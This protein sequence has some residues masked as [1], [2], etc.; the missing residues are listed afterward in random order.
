MSPRPSPARLSRLSTVAIAAAAIAAFASGSYLFSGRDAAAFQAPATQGQWSPVYTVNAPGAALPVSAIHTNVLPNGKVLLWDLTPFHTFNMT[1]TWLW[2][3]TETVS[4]T[5]ISVQKIVNGRTVIFCSGHAFLPDGRLFVAGGGHGQTERIAQI[6]IFDYRTNSWSAGPDMPAVPSGP[7]PTYPNVWAGRWYPTVTALANGEM[8]VASGEAEGSTTNQTPVVYTRSGSWRTLFQ[9]GGV[10]TAAPWHPWYPFLFAAPNGSVF[11]AGGSSH[12]SVPFVPT[13][14]LDPASGAWTPLASQTG[15]PGPNIYQSA[16]MYEPGKILVMGGGT[17]TDGPALN[18]TAAVRMI[19]LNSPAP[20]WQVAASMSFDREYH[21]ATVLADGQVLV[22]GGISSAPPGDVGVMTPELWNPA[23][24]IWSQMAPM[25]R[26]RGYH[27]TAVLLP[28][29]RVM[30]AGTRSNFD[31]PNLEIF[32]PPYLFQG[33]RPVIGYAPAQVG[34][35]QPFVVSTPDTDVTSVSWVRL[36]SVTHAFN[37]N[38]RFARSTV[39][40]ISGGV[41]TRAPS[42]NDA[43]PGHYML[44]LLRNGVPSV[45]RIVRIAVADEPPP[46]DF[47]GDGS[48]DLVWRDFATGANSYWAMNGPNYSTS[49]YLDSVPDLNWEIRAVGDLNGDTHPD[50]IWQ[51]DATGQVA[52]WLYRDGFT[53]IGTPMIATEPAWRI[54]GAADMDQDGQLDLVWRNFATGVL[55]IWHMNGWAQRNSVDIVMTGPTGHDWEVAGIA[56]MNGDSWP[57]LIWRQYVSP[58]SMAAW[59]LTDSIVIDVDYPTPDP[60]NPDLNWRIVGV[61]DIANNGVR[62]G[63]PD[64]IWQRD[65]TNGLAVWYMGGTKGLARQL[66]VWMDPPTIGPNSWYRIV[67]VR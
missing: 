61:A 41:F 49:G 3:P 7:P 50:L 48:P 51:N 12:P 67:G 31:E 46:G 26:K 10:P 6:N 24:G 19:D 63:H 59:F 57:D 21:N 34:A 27:S 54:V 56:D 15:A 58:G 29:G 30:S 17:A 37:Q 66:T 47:T 23:T 35:G 1:D 5:Q 52:A 14:H 44:F 45:A 4:G 33:A 25:A 8:L 42:A 38:Q 55:R 64:L 9:P 53:I 16:V 65:G 22:T 2:D 28:D 62:D 32:S 20:A 43:P 11:R 60:N 13:G 39:T 36:S 18:S 40:P